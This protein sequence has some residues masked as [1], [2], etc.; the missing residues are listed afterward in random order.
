MSS[1]T[2]RLQKSIRRNIL[3]ANITLSNEAV[4]VKRGR[5]SFCIYMLIFVS[6]LDGTVLND[7][8]DCNV[9]HVD[10]IVRLVDFRPACC[11]SGGSRWRARSAFSFA[12]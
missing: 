6:I 2:C 5:T 1:G 9:L 7:L 3:K 4:Y 12:R 11:G 10:A 8:L